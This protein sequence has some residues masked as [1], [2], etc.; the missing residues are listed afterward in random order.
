MKISSSA[1][2]ILYQLKKLVLQLEEDDIRLPLPIFS[3]SSVGQHTRHILEF[4][5]CLFDQVV[6]QEISY[7]KR[8]RD[9]K[10]EK[11]KDYILTKIDT[12]VENLALPYSDS[13]L[14]LYT[15][16]NDNQHITPTSVSREILYTIEHAVHHM[17]ILKIGVLLN[18]PHIPI[19]K[20]FGVA[21]STIRYT[22]NN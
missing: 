17:A 12:I 20:N 18:F 22:E 1:I 4:Y 15:E 7:D 2:A 3:G 14:T 11:N 6:S 16:L 5:L 9:Q 19:D 10:L 13:P 21:E 8:K